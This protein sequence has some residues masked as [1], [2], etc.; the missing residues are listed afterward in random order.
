MRLEE[1]AYLE[2]P[3]PGRVRVVCALDLHAQIQK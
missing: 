3:R 2:W 1:H